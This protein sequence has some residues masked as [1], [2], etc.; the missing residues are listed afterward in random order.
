MCGTKRILR[1]IVRPAVE[2]FSLIKNYQMLLN[3]SI[4]TEN[5]A[6]INN[7]LRR[8]H[9][10]QT[11]YNK[12]WWGAPEIESNKRG[13]TNAEAQIPAQYGPALKDIAHLYWDK[14]HGRAHGPQVSQFL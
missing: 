4:V 9:S 7:K 1:I 12:S 3:D 14:G 11:W 13:R 2:I 10:Y 8:F 6:I 5:N